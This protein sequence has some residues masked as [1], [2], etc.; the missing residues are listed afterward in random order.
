METVHMTRPAAR[1]GFA[2]VVVGIALNHIYDGL[3]MPTTPA[4]WIVDVGPLVLMA[5]ALMIAYVRLGQPQE[6]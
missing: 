3:I 2:R 1:L 6:P 4:Y 5:V